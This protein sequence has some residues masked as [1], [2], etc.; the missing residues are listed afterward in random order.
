MPPAQ[1]RAAADAHCASTRARPSRTLCRLA[2]RS[3]STDDVPRTFDP[4]LYAGV[5]TYCCPCVQFGMNEVALGNNFLIGCCLMC[6]VPLYPNVT[7]R[8]AVAKKS[9]IAS[10]CIEDVALSCCC[11]LCTLAQSANQLGDAADISCAPHAHHACTAAALATACCCCLAACV[12]Q[13]NR[14]GLLAAVPGA[15]ACAQI[16]ATSRWTT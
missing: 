9:G 7:Q 4:P 8:Q 12:L 1:R 13:N 14:A 2:A 11:G 15:D 6:C 5:A 10:N 16:A 3:L